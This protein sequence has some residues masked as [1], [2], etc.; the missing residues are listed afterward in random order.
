MQE[1]PPEDSLTLLR[2]AQAGDQTALDELVGRYLP[3]LQSWARGRLPRWARDLADTDDLIQETIIG[4]LR[5][6]RDFQPRHDTALLAY[7]RQAVWN[8]VQN[9]IRRA[10]RRPGH[11]G[12][13]EY[14]TSFERSALDEVIGTE[15]VQRYEQCLALLDGSDREL[16]VGRLELGLSYQELA[17]AQERPSADAARKAV[18][19][20]LA[21]L[22]KAM[23]HDQ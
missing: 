14:F 22:A 1:K 8:R 10:K 2:R 9:E 15:T 17:D 19:R 12:L 7:L 18:T 5:T 21:H 11:D 3:R 6:L 13:S 4:T 23:R 16:I 20:A